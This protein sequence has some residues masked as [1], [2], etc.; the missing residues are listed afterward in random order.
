[1]ETRIMSLKKTATVRGA[2]ARYIARLSKAALVD[3]LTE[4]LRLAAGEC[5]TELTAEAVR[6]VVEPT[7]R[8]RGDAVPPIHT[9]YWLTAV[10]YANGNAAANRFATRQ[11]ALAA[12]PPIESWS[13]DVLAHVIAH[14]RTGKER[15]ERH[16]D[17]IARPGFAAQAVRSPNGV[18]FTLHRVIRAG[19]LHWPAK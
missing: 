13:H 8:R 14:S 18:T 6:E 10:V 4:A 19:A 2:D 1:M 3:V 5:D 7:L 11:E 16:H 17:W 12:I 9:P 15:D